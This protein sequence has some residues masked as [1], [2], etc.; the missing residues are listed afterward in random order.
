[1]LAALVS[2]WGPSPWC[3]GGHLLTV[4]RDL[5]LSVSASSS[6]IRTQSVCISATLMASLKLLLPLLR[7]CLLTQSHSE[8]LGSRLPHV[9]LRGTVQ[10]VINGDAKGTDLGEPEALSLNAA[11]T[12]HY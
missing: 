4:F 6:Y 2:P 8:A 1:M 11:N 12:T 7:P 3:A 9:N 5:S 10:P